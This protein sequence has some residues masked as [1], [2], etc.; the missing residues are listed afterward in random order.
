MASL[1]VLL[2]DDD[3]LSLEIAGLQLSALGYVVWKAVGGRQALARLE[4]AL[5]TNEPLPDAVITDMQMPGMDGAV[6]CRKIREL[7]LHMPRVFAMSA[8]V[9]ASETVA[10]FDGFVLKPLDLKTVRTTLEPG[11]QTASPAAVVQMP[12]ADLDPIVLQKLRALMPAES[13]D[14]LLSVYLQDTRLRLAGMD[15]LVDAGDQAALRSTAHMIK[16]SASMAGATRV[17]RMASQLEA[18][19]VPVEHQKQI[20]QELRCACDAIEDTLCREDRRK[21]A[22]DQ[23]IPRH[24]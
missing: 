20:I 16:G 1:L 21:E 14:E 8:S 17:A 13:L 23:Q 4:S 18:G 6:L 5:R 12:E 15:H 9:P 11:P 7:G 3:E 19:Q 22:H 2:V 24:G 10:D